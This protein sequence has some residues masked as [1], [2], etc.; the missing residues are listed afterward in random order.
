[1]TIGITLYYDPSQGLL[2]EVRSSFSETTGAHTVVSSEISFVNIR[3]FP[4]CVEWCQKKVGEH[5]VRAYTITEY[6]EH[7]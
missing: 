3:D 4:A 5:M 1:M 2:Q 7:R 6:K